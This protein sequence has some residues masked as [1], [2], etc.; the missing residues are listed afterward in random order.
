MNP[1][2]LEFLS[3]PAGDFR[4]GVP[5]LLFALLLIPLLAAW[6]LHRERTR[7][8]TLRFSGVALLKLA[9]PP[10]RQRWRLFLLA[11]RM[12]AIALLILGMAR[13]QFGRVDRQTYNEG[14][15]IMLVQDVSLSMQA[16]DFYPDRLEASKEV[17]KEFIS[18][19]TG[20]RVGLVIFG[21]DAASLVPL[22]LDSGMVKS[23]VERIRFNI[24]DGTRTAIG[25]GIA[26]ALK[27]L[28]NSEAKSRVM[29]LLT[30]GENNAGK[31]DPLVAAEA[32]KTSKVRIYTIGV[33]SE[34]ARGGFFGMQPDAGLDEESLK[35]I[36][37]ITGGLYFHATS[38]EKLASI[39]AQIDKLEKSRVESTQHDNFNELAPWLAALALALI[40]AE[41]VLGATRFLKIP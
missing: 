35:Q 36:A 4:F 39:Y 37:G 8:A 5:Y 41:L 25:T 26:T 11:L 32:A 7:P 6:V 30:D 13:P 23:F 38:N 31:I 24:V 16:R 20:D 1:L 18:Q 28:E 21:T 9:G 19:R 3:S 2:K 29:I 27:K 33:G 40:F 14:I 12:S 22:T 10:G 15:D 17:V 34:R